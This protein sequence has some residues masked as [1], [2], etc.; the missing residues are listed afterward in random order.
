MHMHMA[1]GP[2]SKL[3]NNGESPNDP[4]PSHGP[5]NQLRVT[6]PPKRRGRRRIIRRRRRG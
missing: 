6:P 4:E 1:H 5:M 3:E 2:G